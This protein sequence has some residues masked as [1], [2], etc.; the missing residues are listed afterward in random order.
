VLAQREADKAS[1]ESIVDKVIDL[2]I[3][4]EVSDPDIVIL[5]QHPSMQ[6]PSKS[7]VSQS[8]KVAYS[9]AIPK[10]AMSKSNRHSSAQST[11]STPRERSAPYPRPI[12]SKTTTS[13]TSANQLR[14]S[15][16]TCTLLNKPLALQCAACLSNRLPDPSIGWTCLTCGEGEM[17]HEFWTCRFCGSVKT[18]SVFG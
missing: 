13:S 8:E 6:G 4:G 2:I 17:P 14:W 18:E 7:A 10:A 12:A 16:P 11:S 3:D 5:D 1:K 9:T 15:C